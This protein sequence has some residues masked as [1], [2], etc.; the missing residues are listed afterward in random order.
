MSD[1]SRNNRRIPPSNLIQPGTVVGHYRINDWLGTGGMGE[2]YLADDIGLDRKVALKFLPAHLCGDNDCRKRFIR[3]AQSA[4][5]L[6]HP[7]IVTIFEVNEHNGIP[8]FA[9]EYIEGESLAD[10]IETGPLAVEEAIRI[11]LQL[12]QGL[13]EAHSKGIIHRDIK[14]SNILIDNAGRVR[15]ADFGLATITGGERL[16]KDYSTV[17]TVNFMSPEQIRSE[18]VDNRS[19]IYSLGV[20]LYE[21]LTGQLPF[22]GQHEPSVMYSILNEEPE[23][24]TKYREGISDKMQAIVSKAIIKDRTLRYQQVEEVIVDIGRLTDTEPTTKTRK[25][26][27]NKRINYKHV[28]WLL[29]GLMTSAII[30][31]AIF[32]WPSNSKVTPYFTQVTRSGDVDLCAISPDGKQIAFTTGNQNDNQLMIQEVAGGE[33]IKLLTAKYIQAVCWSP[34]GTEIAFQA[35]INGQSGVYIIPRLGGI[36]RKYFRAGGGGDNGR[37]SWSSNGQQLLYHSNTIKGKYFLIDKTTSKFTEFSPKNPIELDWV[38]GLDWARDGQHFLVSGEFHGNSRLWI[39]SFAD[40][41][42]YCV[43]EMPKLIL[44]PCWASSGNAIYYLTSESGWD[45]YCLMKLEFNPES[46]KISGASTK[47]LP[48]LLTDGPI[49]ISADGRKI[50]YPLKI[51]WENLWLSKL[52][53]AGNPIHRQITQDKL[54]FCGKALSPN[55]QQIA[56]SALTQSGCELFTILIEGG[57]PQQL[58]HIEG[59]WPVWSPDGNQ[60]A[61]SHTDSSGVYLSIVNMSGDIYKSFKSALISSDVDNKTWAPGDNIIYQLPGN[62][63]FGVLNL[64]NNNITSLISNDS[65]GWAFYPRISPDGNNVA[66]FWNRSLQIDANRPHQSRAYYYSILPRADSI[67]SA[68]KFRDGRGIWLI[69]L[70]DSSQMPVC[71]LKDPC[72]IIS[73]SRN[74]RWIYF[75][76]NSGK[77]IYKVNITDHKIERVITL[78]LDPS[79]DVAMLP[80]E[81]GFVFSAGQSLQDVWMAENFDPDVK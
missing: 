77:T 54:S 62:Q 48:G 60:L 32:L 66:I 44:W 9:M 13:A 46:R 30:V 24:I 41:N 39:V 21:M 8:Y 73:W 55:G 23:P 53:S 45:S 7:N 65:V 72:Y 16:T 51:S 57:Q 58:T 27:Y 19:D 52:D 28:V 80:D 49:S 12:C 78:P 4:A 56:Y 71:W 76:I 18:E 17:G 35:I 26:R 61:F 64:I 74:G 75:R 70:S 22:K 20:V 67:A 68:I 69:S 79:L 81:S 33:P 29:A 37:I 43:P 11:T 63:N 3:E 1:R 50:I 38:R 40:S 47:L 6:N 10:H 14:P 42:A 15:L 34:D 2:V 59:R 36:P 31:T 25:F 5:K